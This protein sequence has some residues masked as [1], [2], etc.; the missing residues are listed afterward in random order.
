MNSW[1][2]KSRLVTGRK[3]FRLSSHLAAAGNGGFCASTGVSPV[4]P[5]SAGH[6][7]QGLLVGIGTTW[8]SRRLK[9][10]LESLG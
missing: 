3:N 6:V 8:A 7:K 1:T 10:S 4:T 2:H 9:A 5:D